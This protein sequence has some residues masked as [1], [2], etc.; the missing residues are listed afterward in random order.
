MSG[1]AE[2]AEQF[3]LGLGFEPPVGDVINGAL[4]C[5]FEVAEYDG[6][7]FGADPESHL[8][9]LNRV[10]GGVRIAVSCCVE[11]HAGVYECGDRRVLIGECELQRLGRVGRVD[12]AGRDG[13]GCDPICSGG[14]RA[15]LE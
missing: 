6:S 3:G 8:G 15:G 9:L 1:E 11:C 5:L 2:C 13:P 12:L 4:E 7:G 14:C 10:V